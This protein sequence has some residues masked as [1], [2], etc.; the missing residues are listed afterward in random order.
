MLIV[1][2]D[3][4]SAIL[5]RDRFPMSK[6]LASALLSLLKPVV[7]SGAS[8]DLMIVILHIF[9]YLCA[10]HSSLFL[11]CFPPIF[12]CMALTHPCSPAVVYSL[13]RVL[14]QQISKSKVTA[15]TDPEFSEAL[16][17]ILDSLVTSPHDKQ[18]ASAIVHLA[19]AFAERNEC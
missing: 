3:L 1:G 18:Q 9:E 15:L 19:L 17:H 14:T 13:L 7:E 2:A 10:K 5:C 4:I 12:W 8:E 16:V 11:A 6:E